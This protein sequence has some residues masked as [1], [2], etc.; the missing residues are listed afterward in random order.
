MMP[1]LASFIVFLVY[2][3]SYAISS[4]SKAYLSMAF[5][6]A[7]ILM[8]AFWL[9]LP[10]TLFADSGLLAFN[11]GTIGMFLV[12][13]GSTIKLKTLLSDLMVIIISV[14]TCFGVAAAAILSAASLLTSIS[15]WRPRLQQVNPERS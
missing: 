15:L 13:M 1:L 11:I 14:M 12:H 9:G 8:V 5:I 4:L 10:R 2:A 3:I 6:G 7:I